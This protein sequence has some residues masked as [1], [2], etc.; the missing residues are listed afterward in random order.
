MLLQNL[1]AIDFLREAQ[2]RSLT[3]TPGLASEL[4]PGTENTSKGSFCR[5]FLIFIHSS[6]NCQYI[7]HGSLFDFATNLETRFKTPA[8]PLMVSTLTERI[9]IQQR[10]L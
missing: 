7:T 3:G 8:H 2:S 4:L 1:L 6:D 10:S 5:L 9:L